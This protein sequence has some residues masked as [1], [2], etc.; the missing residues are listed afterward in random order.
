MLESFLTY[1]KKENLFD[2]MQ[3]I[4]LAVSG[5]LDSMVMLYLFQKAGYDFSV[6]HCN[7][8]LRGNESDDDEKFVAGYC[9]EHNIRLFA[10]RFDTKEY[11]MQEGISIEMAAR[12]LRY[13]WFNE[14]LENERF[15]YLATAHHQDDVIETFFIN[16]SRGTGIRGLSGVKPKAGKLIR[17][18]L[19]TNRVSLIEYAK[20]R[21]I[22]NREDSSNSDTNIQRNFVRHKIIPVFDEFHPAARKNI[23]KT[24]DN[25]FHTEII[26]QQK[27]EEV[28]AAVLKEEGN[29]EILDIEKLKE[30]SDIKTILFELIRDKGF[31]A[32]QIDDIVKALD[33]ESGRKY[34]STTHRLVKDRDEL[35]ISANENK[36]TEL[37]YIDADF[38]EMEQPVSMKFEKISRNASFRFSKNPLVADF[39]LDKLE[40]PLLIRRWKEGE[41]FQPLGMSGFKKISDYFIDEKYSIPDKENAWIL[42]SGNKVVWIVG[43]RMDERF[44]IDRETKNILRVSVLSKR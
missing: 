43:K 42:A 32:E 35:I 6:A 39:D 41:Y 5:G 16:L 31:S 14:I 34:Y 7:F 33:G 30:S 18:L 22:M 3:K 27:V 36:K 17:P 2:P 20:S 44:K 19:F 9:D 23:I 11:A 24:I 38:D 15:D 25:L 10:K 26:F 29:C 28:R 40:F 13:A 21:R 8:Q 4:L 37:F 1:I 12:D